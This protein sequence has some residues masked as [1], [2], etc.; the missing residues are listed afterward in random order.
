MNKSKQKKITCWF[1]KRQSNYYPAVYNNWGSW[2]IVN[3][4]TCPYCTKKIKEMLYQL[5]KQK[6]IISL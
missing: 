5:K 4:Y 3:K 2:S 6:E 1:C